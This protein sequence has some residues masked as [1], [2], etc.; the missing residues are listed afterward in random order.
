MKKNRPVRKRMTR[1]EL[2]GLFL[3]QP[4]PTPGDPNLHTKATAKGHI[5]KVGESAAPSIGMSSKARERRRKMIRS[6]ARS[7]GGK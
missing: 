4:L 1:A 3:G 2:Q 7:M 6:V 5:H